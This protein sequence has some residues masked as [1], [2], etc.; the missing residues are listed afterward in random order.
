M[1]RAHAV[2]FLATMWIAS[3]PQGLADPFGALLTDHG[4][5]PAP[6][7]APPRLHESYVDPV[8]GVTVRRITDPSQVPG[9]SRIRH[10]YSKSNPFNADETRAVFFGSDGSSWLYDTRT[11]MPIKSLHLRSSDPEIQW[12]PTDPNL[13]YHM[14]FVSGSPNVRAVQRYDIRN[15]STRVLRDFREY[16]SARGKLEGNLDKQ[17]RYYALVGKRGGKY[18][19]FVYDVLNDRV[20]RKL[21]VSERQVGDWISVSPSGKYVV[22]MGSDRSRVYDIEMNWLRDL[23]MGSFGHADLCLTAEGRDVMVYD[24]ADHQLDENRNINIADLATGKTSIL[25]RIG[26]GTTPHVSCRNLDLPGWALISTQGPDAKYPNHDFEIFWVKLDDSREVRRV[27]H[28]HSSRKAG[29]YFAEGHAV[30]NRNG[31][32]IIFASNWEGREPIS[33]YLIELPGVGRRLSEARR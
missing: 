21:S 1:T 13:F 30:T 33:D 29:G 24:G 8:F 32:K 15:H 27:A 3:V 10:Y 17:G 28:H 14:E 19:A 22:M 31:T 25:A 7:S 20:S 12:H 9:L 11:W 16:D 6:K 2:V 5:R 4:A 18:E 23:P 26:W